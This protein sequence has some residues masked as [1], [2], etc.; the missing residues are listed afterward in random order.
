M[1][2]TNRSIRNANEDSGRLPGKSDF[3][4]LKADTKRRIDDDASSL[5]PVEPIVSN[6]DLYAMTPPAYTQS[7]AEDEVSV[8]AEAAQEEKPQAFDRSPERGMPSQQ[9]LQQHRS[10]A[11][12]SRNVSQRQRQELE[13]EYYAR[14]SSPQVPSTSRPALG[15]YLTE[16]VLTASLVGVRACSILHDRPAIWLVKRKKI[17]LSPLAAAVL[18]KEGIIGARDLDLFVKSNTLCMNCTD[19]THRIS[20]HSGTRR[21]PIDPLSGVLLGVYD[22][23]GEMMLGLVAGPVEFGKQTSPMMLRLNSRQQGSQDSNTAPGDDKSIPHAAA[24]VAIGTGKGVGRIITA[25]L[26]S[27]MVIMHGITRGFHNLPKV[28]G[29]EVREYENITGLRSGLLVSAK[30]HKYAL[31]VFTND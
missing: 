21:D 22:T 10:N 28:Y 2:G 25:S 15:H 4:I 20:Q 1:T 7:I 9:P 6:A 17:A 26:K 29:E 16:P 19:S 18:T 11:S 5:M 8:D 24:E 14:E 13:R 12:S 3:G 23:V 27:P 30:V 31:I